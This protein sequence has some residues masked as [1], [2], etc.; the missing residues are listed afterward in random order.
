MMATGG[1]SLANLTDPSAVYPEMKKMKTIVMPRELVIR[2]RNDYL[3]LLE[4]AAFT[5]NKPMKELD[6]LDLSKPFFEKVARLM[7]QDRPTEMDE[8]L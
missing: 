5:C 8:S 3:L 2:F 4:F 7:A 1:R 6:A